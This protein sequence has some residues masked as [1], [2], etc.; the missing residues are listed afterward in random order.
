MYTNRLTK[1]QMVLNRLRGAG[2]KGATGFELARVGGWR[3]A[4]RIFDLKGD[5]HAIFS[6]PEKVGE[7]VTARYF[8]T[9]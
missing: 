7:A 4:A 9:E 6:K 8:L 1:K 2:E 5:G 3:Y